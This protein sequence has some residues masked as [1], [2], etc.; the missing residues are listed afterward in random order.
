MILPIF[1]S[2]L[3]RR[4]LNGSQMSNKHSTEPVTN[5][6]WWEG[7]TPSPRQ[8]ETLKLHSIH[9]L[10]CNKSQLE[11]KNDAERGE[12]GLAESQSVGNAAYYILLCPR[13]CSG[14]RHVT[15]EDLKHTPNPQLR[16]VNT[17]GTGNV[18]G[19]CYILIY[20]RCWKHIGVYVIIFLFHFSYSPKSF[21]I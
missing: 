4:C 7:R 8:L 21:P 19:V 16:N 1:T 13:W 6:A 12:E 17:E 15:L 5:L 11:L 10:F 18:S 3:C 20:V 14:P 9:W 2:S